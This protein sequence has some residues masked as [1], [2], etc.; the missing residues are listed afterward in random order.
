MAM[1]AMTLY[2]A[3]RIGFKARDRATAALGPARA[4]ELAMDAVRRDLE[5][6]L[7][8]RGILAGAGMFLAGDGVEV[9]GTSAVQFYA[10]A[11]LPPV[12]STPGGMPASPTRGPSSVDNVDPIA[13]GGG[14]R[15]VELLL[16]PPQ[17]GAPA[18]AGGVLVRRVV[19]NL[20]APTEPIPEEE[21]VCRGVTAFSLRYFD[22]LQW[23]AEWDSTQ[24]GDT[25]PMAV[26]VAIEL[27]GSLDP[28]R[29]ATDVRG[30]VANEATY[31]TTRTFFL[32]CR[33]EAALLQG[34]VQ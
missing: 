3:M 31:R 17:N 1:I 30:G 32:P 6:A 34:V 10:M 8:L 7:P 4:A 26:E 5:S 23:Y 2:Q 24:Y 28:T 11:P 12:T 21:I 9:P 33:D 18:D 19:R 16:R 29:A 22:G 13:Y 14:V 27:R 20:L 25:L 15:R